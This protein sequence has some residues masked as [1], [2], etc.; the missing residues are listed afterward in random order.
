MAYMADRPARPGNIKEGGYQPTSDPPAPPSG[1]VPPQAVN[2]ITGN[3][4]PPGRPT[5]QRPGGHTPAPPASED[6]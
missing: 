2:P 6:A 3:P 5:P 4:N 1:Q